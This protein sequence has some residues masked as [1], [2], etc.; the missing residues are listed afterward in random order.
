MKPPVVKPA[1]N[2]RSWISRKL[3][4]FF[5]RISGMWSIR[6]ARAYS[7]CGQSCLRLARRLV[8]G[9]G[10]P[11]GLV[12]FGLICTLSYAGHLLLEKARPSSYRAIFW[13]ET[14]VY[15]LLPMILADKDKGLSQ[16]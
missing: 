15:V 5:G 13:S 3:T 12:R 8:D 11:P 7:M 16:R 9:A 14:L 10:C 2:N 4:R 1:G 6:K